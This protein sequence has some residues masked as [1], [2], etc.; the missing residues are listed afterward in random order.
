M[1]NSE[2][3]K[4]KNFNA[5]TDP[6]LK[7][8]CGHSKCDKRSVSQEHLDRVQKARE[9]AGFAFKVTSGGRCPYHPNEIHRTTP[10]D[11][12][13]FQAVD[14]AVSGGVMRGAVVNA[15]IKS[16]CNAI[17]V[18]KTFVH[19]GYRPELAEGEIVM[20]TYS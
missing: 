13:K 20:W 10:A 1:K 18:A 17:G 7:C 2:E 15:G 4:T 16:G 11:H 14:I 8:A 5:R 9:L 12:Q 6:K 19:L 3:I